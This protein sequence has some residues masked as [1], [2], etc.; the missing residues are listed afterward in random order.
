MFVK[1]EKR[2]NPDAYAYNDNWDAGPIYQQ[3]GLS[4]INRFNVKQCQV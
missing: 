2:N 3:Q 4:V 1:N